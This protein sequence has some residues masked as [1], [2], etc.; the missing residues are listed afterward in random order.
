M[1]RILNFKREIFKC[2]KCSHVQMFKCTNVQMLEC[3]DL[4]KYFLIH[5]EKAVR[6]KCLN[7]HEH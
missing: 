6:A 2:E 4:T 1:Y 3:M 5:H 7:T